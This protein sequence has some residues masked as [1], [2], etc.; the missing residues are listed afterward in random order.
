MKRAILGAIGWVVLLGSQVVRAADGETG[1]LL[2]QIYPLLI[3][4]VVFGGIFYFM[5]IRPQRKR[6][7]QMSTLLESLKRGDT[8]ITAGGIH[9]EIESIG[10]TSVVLNL[11]DGSK[12]RMAKTS[13]VRKLDKS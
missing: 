8:V 1:S 10:D 4:V 9:G 12:L 3:L 2:D 6:Q 13:I 11:E 5:L 7:Q